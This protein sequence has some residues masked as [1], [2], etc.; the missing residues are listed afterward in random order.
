MLLA[1]ALLMPVRAAAQESGAPEAIKQLAESCDAHKF[2]T[3]IDV[4]GPDGGTRKSKVK[5]C[6]QEGQTDADWVRTLKD[7]I[8]KVAGNEKM[9]AAVKNQIV[10]AINAEIGKVENALTTPAGS[11]LLA[12]PSPIGNAPRAAPPAPPQRG[13]YDTPEYSVFKPL[14]A[15]KPAETASIAGKGAPP[16]PKLSAPRLTFRCQDTTSIAGEGPCDALTRSTLLTVKADDDVPGG[17]SLRFMRRADERAEVDLK[18]RHGQ[19]RRMPLPP[20]VC[21]GV[22]GSRVTIE[23]VRRAPGVPST[24][25]VVDTKG[26]FELTC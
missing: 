17:T 6:G 1:S 19:S 25:Q 20:E 23:V 24:G 12:I 3:M 4:P 22:S 2:E 18:L 13:V 8:A 14:P 16:V 9:P 21:R 5:I 7:T 26:P 11:N 10:T 15:P